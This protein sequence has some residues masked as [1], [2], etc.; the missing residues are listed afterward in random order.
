MDQ[1]NA[2]RA[3]VRVVEVGTFTR[4]AE[5]LDLPKPTVTKLI[6]QLEGHLRAQLLNRTTRRVTVTM[7]GA[8]YYERAL[9]VLG[10]IDELDQSMTSSQARPSGRLRIDVSASFA[11]DI[12]LPA[13]PGFHGR[14]PE[15]QIDMGLSDRP[16]DLIG[17]NLDLAIRAGAIDDQSLIARRIGEMM[18]ITCAT[19]GYLA[20]HGTP[21]HP[22]DLEDG[23]LAIGYR[24][25]GTSRIMPF[26]FASPKETIEIQGNYVVSLNDGTGYVAAGLAGLGV[27]Q[28]PT[29]MAMAHIASGRLVPILTDW[30]TKPKPLHIIYPPNRHLSNKVRVFVDWLAELFARN[31]LL[32]G[33]PLLPCPGGVATTPEAVARQPEQAA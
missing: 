7:D 2:M 22:R 25:A 9:R 14:Y 3:F 26:T 19:P 18:L 30:C 4:A 15:I 1:L 10:E 16:A 23:H 8:A 17:E 24:R 5:L 32:Q 31:E 33:K 21:R 20:K 29:F 12:I 11:T 27:M 13:L 28:V 6:Q